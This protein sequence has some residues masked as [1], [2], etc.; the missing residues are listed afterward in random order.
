[1]NRE[2]AGNFLLGDAAALELKSGA[3]LLAVNSI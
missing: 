1:M 3:T 2:I